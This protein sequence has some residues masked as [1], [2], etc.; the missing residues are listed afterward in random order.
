MLRRSLERPLSTSPAGQ[1]AGATSPS[2][3]HKSFR[4]SGSEAAS[5]RA[6]GAQRTSEAVVNKEPMKRRYDAMVAW[7]GKQEEN[8]TSVPVL[9]A[10]NKFKMLWRMEKTLH[11]KT[12]S[13]HG[14]CDMCAQ[15][16]DERTKRL[17]N[18]ST[19]VLDYLKELDNLEAL[20]IL[21]CEKQRRQLDLAGLTAIKYP[22]SMWCIIA[23]AATQRNFGKST[24]P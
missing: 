10:R 15:F 5:G 6:P 12:V 8:G 19:E 17:G 20:H 24:H 11:E 4:T 3:G 18:K 13:T 23:D 2:H 9:P 22:T 14:K 21:F 1:R 16:T 7:F